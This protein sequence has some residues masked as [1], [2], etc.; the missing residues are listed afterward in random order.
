VGRRSS[1]EESALQASG[2]S[3]GVPQSRIALSEGQPLV[4]NAPTP[5]FSADGEF[6]GY[7]DAGQEY[8]V[9]TIEEGWALVAIDPEWPIWIELQPAPDEAAADE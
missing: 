4:L 7:L 8:T 1:Q 3:P 2:E 6:L 5:A 9:I